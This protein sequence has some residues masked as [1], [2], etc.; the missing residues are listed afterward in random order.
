MGIMYARNK[1][2]LVDKT[3]GQK[4]VMESELAISSS[5]SQ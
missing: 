5:I 4:G 3:I 2:Q 1:L